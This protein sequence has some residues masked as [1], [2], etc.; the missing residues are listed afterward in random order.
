MLLQLVMERTSWVDDRFIDRSGQVRVTDLSSADVIS[1]ED[2]NFDASP[3]ALAQ[4]FSVSYD[5]AKIDQPLRR[6]IHSQAQTLL[7]L[8]VTTTSRL[9][10]KVFCQAERFKGRR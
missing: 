4:Q 5:E 7:F 10:Q 1:L 3:E 8:M 9:I 2:M 6:H